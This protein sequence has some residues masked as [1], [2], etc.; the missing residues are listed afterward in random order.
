MVK[1]H[2]NLLT[3]WVAIQSLYT[4]IKN[5]NSKNI[6][7]FLFPIDI[8]SWFLVPDETSGDRYI[9]SSFLQNFKILHDYSFWK[10][11]LCNL[12]QQ[13]FDLKLLKQYL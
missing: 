6:A 11:G 4:I 13:L 8:A 2:Q 5:N 12:F 10:Y 3:T 1:S 7:N 9:A